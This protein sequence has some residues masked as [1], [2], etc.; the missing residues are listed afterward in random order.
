MLLITFTSPMQTG[1]GTP[2][3]VVRQYSAP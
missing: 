3:A 2:A 1:H